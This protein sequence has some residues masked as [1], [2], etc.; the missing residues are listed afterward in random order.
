M[1]ILN[2]IESL[3]PTISKDT[4]AEDISITRSIL[5]ETTIPAY[6]SASDIFKGWKFKSNEVEGLFT[7]IKRNVDFGRGN[8]IEGINEALPLVI[9]NL[10]MMGQMAHKILTEEVSSAGISYRRANILQF[11]EAVSF[12]SRYASKLL[13]YVFI[14]E[15]HHAGGSESLRSNL[16][17]AE[18]EWVVSNAVYFARVFAAVSGKPHVVKSQIEDVPDIIVNKDN[19]DILPNTLGAKKIDPFSMGFIPVVLNPFYHIGLMRAEY[20]AARYNKAKDE[21]EVVRLRK[22]RL[23]KQMEGKSDAALE[24]EIDYMERR[25]Q[26]LEAKI[27]KMEKDYG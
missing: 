8:V 4:I 26:T 21:L 11:I 27:I 9:E 1:K 12:V 6:S 5:E 19:A 22:F 18:N 13:L 10:D 16:T 14:A 17:P 15:T 2:Y 7:T 24:K 20:Q 3:L 23:E 25:V